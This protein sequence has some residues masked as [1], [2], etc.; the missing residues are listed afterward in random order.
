MSVPSEKVIPAI[1][2][3]IRLYNSF[4][5]S[6]P[7]LGNSGVIGYVDHDAPKEV[8]VTVRANPD[9]PKSRI[10]TVDSQTARVYDLYSQI[11]K[12]YRVLH[13]LEITPRT[14]TIVIGID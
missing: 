6:T 5:D 14:L 3:T 2:K 11:Y 7:D 13:L 9:L 8:A 12:T 1:N 10:L 4:A